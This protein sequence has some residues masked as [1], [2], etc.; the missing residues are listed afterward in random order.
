MV[1]ESLRLAALAIAL[2]AP[3]AAAAAPAPGDGATRDQARI[4]APL[5]VAR[6]DGS[7][8]ITRAIHPAPVSLAA[9][10]GGLLLLAGEEPAPQLIDR[11]PDQAREAL[12]RAELEAD[13]RR[14]YEEAVDQARQA[15]LT[16][17]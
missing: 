8:T 15:E 9:A 10:T 5:L 16:P 4:E 6:S 12:R 17:Q 14:A 1:N 7:W 3:F 11:D 2:A 13:E